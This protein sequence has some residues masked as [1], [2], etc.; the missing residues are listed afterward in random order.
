[1]FARRMR[2]TTKDAEYVFRRSI[3][4]FANLVII[5]CLHYIRFEIPTKHHLEERSTP[6]EEEFTL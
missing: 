5:V 2:R 3:P 4:R 1:M 6:N